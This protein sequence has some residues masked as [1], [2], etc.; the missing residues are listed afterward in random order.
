[1]ITDP[2]WYLEAQAQAYASLAQKYADDE[3]NR[4]HWQMKLAE[5]EK[6]IAARKAQHAQQLATR[7]ETPRPSEGM[8]REA[9][10]EG[11]LTG[12][13]PISQTQA[14]RI[15]TDDLRIRYDRMARR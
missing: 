4:K 3:E 1:M 9:P 2:I 13:Q 8:S 11:L 12:G 7:L 10:I 14:A 6:L 5:V 15:S